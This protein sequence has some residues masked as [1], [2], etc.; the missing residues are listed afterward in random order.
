MLP[1]T[2]KMRRIGKFHVGNVLDDSTQCGIRGTREMEYRV[3]L[4]M[5]REHLTP[6][7]FI[8]DNFAIQQYFDSKYNQDMEKLPSCETIAC[9]AVEDFCTL[10]PNCTRIAVNIDGTGFA[11]LEAEY[12]NPARR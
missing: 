9:Q 5:S 1:T 4:E 6:E 11:G 10:V 7:G 12:I 3:E 8:I 2:L